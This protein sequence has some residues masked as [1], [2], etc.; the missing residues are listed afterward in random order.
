MEA[1]VWSFWSVK[2]EAR[3][4]RQQ[5]GWTWALVEGR[6]GH[7]LEGRQGHGHP[8]DATT[9]RR[10]EAGRGAVGVVRVRDEASPRGGVRRQAEAFR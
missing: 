6:R 4:V 7:G 2:Q 1:G 5:E 9:R 3:G 8:G 10:V